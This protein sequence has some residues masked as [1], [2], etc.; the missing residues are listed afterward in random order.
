MIGTQII[1]DAYN[2]GIEQTTLEL[3]LGPSPCFSLRIDR[4]CA[5]FLGFYIR[6]LF[7]LI[8]SYRAA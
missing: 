3:Y 2:I 1:P 4:A 5:P 7:S 6:S 8:H